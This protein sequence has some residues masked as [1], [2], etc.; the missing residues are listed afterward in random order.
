GRP[1]AGAALRRAGRRRAPHPRGARGGAALHGLR[2]VRVARRDAALVAQGAERGAPQGGV[3]PRRRRVRLRQL[4]HRAP[5]GGVGGAAAPRRRPR[6][7]RGAVGARALA[8]GGGGVARGGVAPHP[9]GRPVAGGGR[10]PPRPPVPRE[11]PALP[12]RPRLLGLLAPAG[13]GAL[14]PRAHYAR[15]GDRGGAR[16]VRAHAQ[17]APR[18]R[19]RARRAPRAAPPQRAERVRAARPRVELPPRRLRDAARRA[20]RRGRVVVGGPQRLRARARGARAGGGG[21]RRDRRAHRLVGADPARLHGGHRGAR[22]LARARA[23]GAGGGR[24]RDAR[25]R[26]RGARA[27]VRGHPRGVHAARL[28]DRR[29]RGG[30]QHL[31]LRDAGG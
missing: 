4:P 5:V 27:A 8:R 26:P 12:A 19:C 29:D 3:A 11:R 13:A 9:P 31:P 17:P 10:A 6:D 2:L 20:G 1:R 18:A 7:R 16:G 28:R 24:A 30:R 15:R 25:P 14:H 23:G 21:G 22:A